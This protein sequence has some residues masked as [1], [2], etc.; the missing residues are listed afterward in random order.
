MLL[1]VKAELREMTSGIIEPML[2]LSLFQN[3]EASEFSSLPLA[4]THPISKSN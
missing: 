1:K 2:G 3:T 4:C